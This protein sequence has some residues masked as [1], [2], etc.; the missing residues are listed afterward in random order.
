MTIS[1]FHEKQKLTRIAVAHISL[2]LLSAHV[3][4]ETEWGSS[5]ETL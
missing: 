3:R 4:I 1:S 2:Q 5:T